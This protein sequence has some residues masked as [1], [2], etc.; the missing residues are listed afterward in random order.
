MDITSYMNTYTERVRLGSITCLWSHCW[1]PLEAQK[2]SHFDSETLHFA[3]CFAKGWLFTL[4]V[5][6]KG[7]P[8]SSHGAGIGTVCKYTYVK[9]YILSVYQQRQKL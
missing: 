8:C 6:V 5:M 2:F 1:W 9:S 4:L 7:E 3:L